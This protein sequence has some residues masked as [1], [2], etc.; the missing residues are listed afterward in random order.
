MNV[1]AGG[2]AGAR[3]RYPAASRWT[4]LNV[5]SRGIISE[6]TRAAVDAVVSGQ[7]TGDATRED[8]APIASRVR[9]NFAALIGA[10]A[11]E[12]ALTKNVSDGLNAIANAIDWR[13][14]DEVVLSPALEH[15]NNLLPWLR[16]ESIG[17]RVVR[18]PARAGAIDAAAMARAIG[19][20][21]RLA[22]LASVTFA[23]GFRAELAPIAE[24]CRRRGAL[25]VIDA[26]QSTGVLRH[27]VEAE[28]I[29][30]LATSSSK[31]LLGVIGSGLLYVSARRIGEL[32]PATLSRP[33]VAD[34]SHE[35]GLGSDR[36][37]LQPDARRFEVG[38]HNWAGLAALDSSLAELRAAG[39]AAIESHALGLA[40]SLRERLA[41]A[42]QPVCL[43]P[44]RDAASHIVTVGPLEPAAGTVAPP[45]L[46]DFA[47][48]LAASRVKHTV[49]RGQLRFGFHL[50]NDETDVE[51]VVEAAR[52]A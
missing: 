20:R 41:A 44:A 11:D 34:A 49:R 15:P 23:P 13:I 4:Y 22:A 9:A 19:Q 35:S 27:D 42:G 50:Y 40:A 18:V 29:D 21:T 17:V 7:L 45:A 5:P 38:N 2:L 3:A 12:I 48:R 25:L 46:A 1:A 10:R 24:A 47:A 36:P 28:G 43:P 37:P 33:A 31:G 52:Q 16:L 30:A 26:V 39:L 14:G 8:W 6:T 51:R 32:T